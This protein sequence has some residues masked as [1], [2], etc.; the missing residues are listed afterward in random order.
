MQAYQAFYFVANASDLDMQECPHY[1]TP[2]VGNPVQIS[3]RGVVGFS[4]IIVKLISTIDAILSQSISAEIHFIRRI[5]ELF[6]PL[7]ATFTNSVMAQKSIICKVKLA[8]FVEPS[9]PS[10]LVN[11]LIS[12][13]VISIES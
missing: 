5:R 3:L 1:I 2:T 10:D 12:Q 13:G 9:I 7:S 11:L 8:G 4:Q 6:T